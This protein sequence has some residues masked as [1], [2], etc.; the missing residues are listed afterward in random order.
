MKDN[1]HVRISPELKSQA[2]DYANK[3]GLTFSDVVRKALS[4]YLFQFGYGGHP[5]KR[6]F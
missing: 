6:K 2:F 4:S 5:Y 1:L 3:N